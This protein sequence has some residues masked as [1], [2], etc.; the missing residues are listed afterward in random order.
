LQVEEAL[1][2][3]ELEQAV[4]SERNRL[5]R[6]LHDA[7]TQTLFSASLIAEAL[8]VTWDNNIEEGR[9][10]LKEL[11]RMSRG[12]LAEMRTLLMELRP[13]AVV[14]VS[15]EDLLCQLGEAVTGREGI[16]VE[17][18]IEGR[19]QLPADVHITLY[20][21]TQEALNNVVK[22]AR[23][24]KVL[25]RLSCSPG[26]LFHD[27]IENPQQIE[28]SITDDGQGFDPDR[29]LPEHLG[30]EIMHE[31]AHSIGA[32]LKINSLPGQGAEISVFWESNGS[33]ERSIDGVFIAD[34]S[35]DS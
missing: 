32:S 28:L 4:T 9:L 2:Q 18:E 3:S 1:R 30:L 10:L 12:A 5:A 8:P 20:R 7:V 17:L 27:D 29:K 25:I 34:S 11:R 6:E 16:P 35:N 21:I 24:S 26:Y 22:H 33:K 14:D 23:A 15:L 31:R 13:S 19:C